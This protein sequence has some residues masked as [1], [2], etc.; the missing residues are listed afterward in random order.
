MPYGFNR[1][2]WFKLSPIKRRRI[3]LEHAEAE[4]VDIPDV[5]PLTCASCDRTFETKQ[6]KGAAVRWCKQPDRPCA[7]VRK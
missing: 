3:M 7:K 1:V 5:N 6:A 2:R 4:E